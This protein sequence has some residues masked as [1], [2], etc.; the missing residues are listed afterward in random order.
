VKKIM[1]LFVLF[2]SVVSCFSTVKIGIYDGKP[3]CYVDE[4]KFTGMYIE[5]IQKIAGDNNLELVFVY[6]GFAELYQMLLKGEIDMMPG[7]VYSSERAELFDFNKEHIL[8]SY[9]TV[10]VSEE[11]DFTSLLKLGGKKIAVV[12]NAINYTGIFGI[13]NIF[14]SLNIEVEY[15]EKYSY[16]EVLDAVEEGEAEAGVVD[17]FFGVLNEQDYSLK[18][19]PI[20]LN[21]SDIRYAFAKGTSES[22]ELIA[23]VDKSLKKMKQDDSSF[24]YRNLNKYLHNKEY[25]DN[26]YLYFIIIMCIIAFFFFLF[27]VHYLRRGLKKSTSEIEKKESQLNIAESKVKETYS[28]LKKSN[29]ILKETL[30]KFGNLVNISGTLGVKDL[31]EDDFSKIFLVNMVSIIKEADYGSISLVRDGEWEFVAAVGYDLDV[32]KTLHLKVDAVH[33]TQEVKIIDDLYD[34]YDQDFSKEEADILRRGIKP[35]KQSLIAPFFIDNEFAGNLSLDIA[36][37]SEKEFSEETK[38]IL[39]SV[40]GIAA[41]F[42]ELKKNTNTKERFQKNI[43]LSLVKALE[44]YDE[45]TRGHSERVAAYASILSKQLGNSKEMTNKIYWASLVHDVGKIFIPRNIL[46]KVTVLT[47]EEFAEIKKHSEKGEEIL[48]ETEG[49]KEI[50]DIVR[51]HHERYDGSGYPD[52]LKEDE[53]PL[54]SQIIAIADSFDAMTTNRLYRRKMSYEEAV[55]DLRN[56]IDFLYKKELIDAFICPELLKLFVS[57]HS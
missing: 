12:K 48:K 16:A 32:L 1:I 45:Y 33:V 3:L 57:L 54:E 31:N 34:Q 20:V 21:P 35:F 55:E 43:V 5:L 6:D 53:I 44:Y 42:L 49:M 18:S 40:S 41:S 38:S 27:S 47:T 36:K 26:P 14:D 10:Y 46:N 9:G 25:V 4:G 24:F 51:H 56:C 29:Q 8:S 37:D 28:E 2:L 30:E 13:R 7:V 15:I 17:G 50:A 22:A 11:A 19:T 52:G 39:N 23:I